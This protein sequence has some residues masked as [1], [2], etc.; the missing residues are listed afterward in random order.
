MIADKIE[1]T[2]RSGKA[3]PVYVFHGEEDF[4][5]SELLHLAPGIFVPD[6]STRSFN[7]D[8]LYGSE[9][10][11]SQVITVAQGYPMMAER[12]LVI[13][14]DAEKVLRAKPAGT[15]SKSKK[16]TN[17]DPLQAY[18]THP[19]PDCILI[20]D[21]QKFGA[22]NQSPFRELAE[23]TEVIEFPVFKDAEVVEWLQSRASSLERKLS[24]DAARLMV[25]HLGTSLRAHANEL[26]KLAT[27]T[28]GKKEITGKDVEQIVG[29]S[30]EHNVFELTKA[31]GANNKSLA[32]TIA[33]RM[34]EADAGQRQLLFVMLARFIEQLTI[35]REMSTKGQ[36]E[37]EIADALEMRGGAAYFVKETITTARRYTR[38]RLD[39]ALRALVDAEV[40]TRRSNANDMLVI[41]S[42]LLKLLPEPG[43]R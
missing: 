9:T 21:M 1:K 38:E 8:L 25:A 35:A 33:L 16:K 6:E 17:D 37:K 4:L 22:K 24:P 31:I 23:K 26:E 14:R 27:Y 32:A 40:Q 13:V 41:E 29:A 3:A 30:R 43:L 15:A 19:N 10:N 34:L 18:L 39:N 7:F 5:R 2:W 11:I 20:F 12:R 42:L 36:A 28:S